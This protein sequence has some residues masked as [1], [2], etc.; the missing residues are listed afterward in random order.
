MGMLNKRIASSSG[1]TRNVR[2]LAGSMRPMDVAR[3]EHLSHLQ[4]KKVLD[5]MEIIAWSLQ[6]ADDEGM[7]G[8]EP[9]RLE[10]VVEAKEAIHIGTLG[11][12]Q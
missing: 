8:G 3:D 6:R 11:R 9:D 5:E 7:G 4:K 2:P 1:R 12:T 10:D